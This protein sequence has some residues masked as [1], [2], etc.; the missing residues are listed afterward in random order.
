MTLIRR[1]VTGAS[2]T[3][4][5]VSLV[6]C[7]SSDTGDAAQNGATAEEVMS[8]AKSAL[9]ATSGVELSLT[10]ED[11]RD[12]GDFLRSAEGVITDAPAFQGTAGG[13]FLGFN[14]EDVEVRSVDGEFYVNA[15]VIGWD[16]YDPAEL[17]AP[18]PATLLDPDT[19]V[20]NVLVAATDLEAGE[21]RR[22]EDDNSVVV[23]PYTATVPGTAVKAILPCAPDDSFE[24][25]FT[26]DDEGR[27]RAADLT[28]VFFSGGDDI[29]YTI[30]VS[31]YG[32]AQEITAPE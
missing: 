27:L 21:Q 13:R 5:S 25:V 16:T 26:V 14:A 29:T 32:I 2:T 24:A 11:Q 19:G 18:D 3:L 1:L 15:P 7:S 17:C 9:D 10:T 30:T 31:A 23:T 22:A 20:S 4:L 8:A 12:E 6:A 28:G